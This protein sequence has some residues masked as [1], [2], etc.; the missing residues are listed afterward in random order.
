MSPQSVQFCLCTPLGGLADWR[1]RKPC[2]VDVLDMPTES[3]GHLPTSALVA[4]TKFT[5][6]V[7]DYGTLDGTWMKSNL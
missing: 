5:L 2:Q 4:P 3:F 1:H 6:L 7:G